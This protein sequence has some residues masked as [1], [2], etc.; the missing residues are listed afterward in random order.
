MNQRSMLPLML[1]QV[2]IRCLLT[3]RPLPTAHCPLFFAHPNNQPAS[4]RT[5][6]APKM[7]QNGFGL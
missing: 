6:P 7:I 4:S 5:A 3:Y 1:N 2:I